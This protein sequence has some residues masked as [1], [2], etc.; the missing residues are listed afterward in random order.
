MKRISKK[1]YE[2]QLR[3]H[4]Q[5]FFFIIG[6]VGLAMLLMSIGMLLLD[7]WMSFIGAIGTIIL[8][9]I[10]ILKGLQLNAYKRHYAPRDYKA[11]NAKRQK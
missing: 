10:A 4:W 11:E 8:L 3:A 9:I 6:I 2:D 5:E 7:E 1:L